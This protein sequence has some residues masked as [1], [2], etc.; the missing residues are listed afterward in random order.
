MCKINSTENLVRDGK[1]LNDGETND[2]SIRPEYIQRHNATLHGAIIQ[3][4]ISIEYTDRRAIRGM[5]ERGEASVQIVSQGVDL[6]RER[7]HV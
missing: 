1:F 6:G 5:S 4:V 2:G 7:V 3:V